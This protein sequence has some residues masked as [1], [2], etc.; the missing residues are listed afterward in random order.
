[1]TESDRLAASDPDQMS[2]FLRYLGGAVGDES[3]RA[4]F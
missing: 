2:Q 4:C 3:N 1:V